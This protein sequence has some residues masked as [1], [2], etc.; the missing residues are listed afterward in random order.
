M[1]VRERERSRQLPCACLGNGVGSAAVLG[2]KDYKTERVTSVLFILH[3]RCLG[4][5][6]RLILEG[7]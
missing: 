5:V 6:Q 4:N 3:W 1:E 2:D 7:S